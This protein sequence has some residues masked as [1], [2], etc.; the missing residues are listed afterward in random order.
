MALK[1]RRVSFVKLKRGEKQDAPRVYSASSTFPALVPDDLSAS[2]P[3]AAPFHVHVLPS[4]GPAT[5]KRI[6]S[7]LFFLQASEVSQS[8][9][10]ASKAGRQLTR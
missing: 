8:R 10:R 4:S 1:A 5:E 3:K 7:E 2:V 9:R 6:F